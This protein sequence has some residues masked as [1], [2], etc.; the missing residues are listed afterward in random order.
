MLTTAQRLRQIGPERQISEKRLTTVKKTHKST[1][2][3][4]SVSSKFD[5]G[6]LMKTRECE[7]LSAFGTLKRYVLYKGLLFRRKPHNS[8]SKW[9]ISDSKSH[10]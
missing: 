1:G 2:T 7:F 9:T 3:K 5:I 10:W 6:D 4:L 8:K